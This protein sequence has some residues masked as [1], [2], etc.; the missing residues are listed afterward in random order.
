MLRHYI[1]D[2]AERKLCTSFRC[3]RAGHAT[4]APQRRVYIE[5]IIQFLLKS[6]VFF[7][8]GLIQGILE[9]LYDTCVISE[10]GVELWMM[11]E[12]PFEREG[13]AEALESSASF[14]TWLRETE[15]E[16]GQ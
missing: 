10:E 15:P 1:E 7:S 3:S 11:S 5:S 9:T 12:D 16:P 13:K 8:S 2:V 6:N 4:S 14:L